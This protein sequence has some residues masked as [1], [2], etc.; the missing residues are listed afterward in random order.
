[1]LQEQS[2]VRWKY[3]DFFQRGDRLHTSESDAY[4]RQI[5]IY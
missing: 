5:L 4:K 3:F 1:M 2:Y